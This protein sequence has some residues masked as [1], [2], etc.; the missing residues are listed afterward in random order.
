MNSDA[1][2]LESFKS[3]GF[4]TLTE[5]QK[6]AFPVV[7]RRGNCLLVA[8]TGSGKTEA[9]IIPVISLMSQADRPT[10]SIRTIYVTPLRALNNDVFRRIIFYAKKM[11]LDVQI[12]HGDTTTSAR[13]KIVTD[14]PDILITT[15]ESLGVILT[16]KNLLHSLKGLEWIVIDEVHE[17]ISNERG[18]HLALSL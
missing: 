13:R 8:P 14:P 7:N 4:D 2:I 10:G 15:P 18:A 9:A 16:N 6:Q 1:L 17:L 11:K 12:R 3:N 5:I